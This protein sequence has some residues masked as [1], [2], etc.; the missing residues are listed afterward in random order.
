MS[1]WRILL[2]ALVLS[3]SF[4]RATLAAMEGEPLQIGFYL[5]GI[6]EANLADVKISL[7]L[8]ADEIGSYR[9]FQAKT[10]TY[11]DM[12]TLRNDA[13]SGRVHIVVAPGMELAEQFNP[14]DIAEGFAGQKQGV[15]TGLVLI[16]RKDRGIQKFDDLRGKRVLKMSDDRLSDIYLDTQC[17]VRLGTACAGQF[18]VANEK[19]GVLAIHKVFF[20]QADA[21]L[22]NI[23]ALNT[24]IALNPQVMQHIHILQDWKSKSTSF[25]MML[26][27]TDPDFRKRVLDAAMQVATTVRGK[28]ILDLFNTKAMVLANQS[29]LQPFWRLS[30]E[31]MEMQ[32]T[33]RKE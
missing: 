33:A 23:D 28:Q 12:R 29:D 25:G 7:Q 11:D 9:G 27:R 32:N 24:A 26:T 3:F 21:A 19:R 4:G 8:W 20:G 2:H 30:R 15:E 17:L 16:A 14:K 13:L 6:R 10:V 31:Y 1:G 18:N 5:P 22:V